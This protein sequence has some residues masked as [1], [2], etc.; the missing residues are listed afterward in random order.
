MYVL[1]LSRTAVSVI[2]PTSAVSLSTRLA[3]LILY[4]VWYTKGRFEGGS[5]IAQ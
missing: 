5:C 3:L 4:G 1:Y 2:P